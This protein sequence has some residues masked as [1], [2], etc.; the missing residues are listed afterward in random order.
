[1][2]FEEARESWYVGYADHGA[3]FVEG[4]V[5]CH[6]EAACLFE[7]DV[8]CVIHGGFSSYGSILSHEVVFAEPGRG[9]EVVEGEGLVDVVDD[10]FSDLLDHGLVC[11]CGEVPDLFQDICEDCAAQFRVSFVREMH[12]EF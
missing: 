1:M 12:E 2:G 7:A 11:A 3:D 5:C 8:A 10:E 9:G 6:E 4:E